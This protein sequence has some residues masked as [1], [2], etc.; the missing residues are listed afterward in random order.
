MGRPKESAFVGIL[1][2]LLLFLPSCV[3][4]HSPYEKGMTI[5][6]WDLDDLSLSATALPHLGELLSSQVI[7]T[8]KKKGDYTFVER[9]RLLL[10]LQEL[11]LGTTTLVD[12]STRLKLGRLIG[13]RWMVFG[14]YQAIGDKMRIDLRL[15]DVENGKVL[16]ASEKTTTAA[17]FPE[18][19]ETAK[20]A[21]EE[22]L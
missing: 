14:G 7:E 22:L 16:K 9:D 3:P 12:E 4:K 2:V 6:V 1:I 5:A 11:H 19:L 13:A 20:R 8:L 17:G 10:A 15:V 21:A 18:W